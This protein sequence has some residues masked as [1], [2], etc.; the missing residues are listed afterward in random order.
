MREVQLLGDFVDRRSRLVFFAVVIVVGSV[1]H[2]APRDWNPFIVF[3]GVAFEV[4]GVVG[5]L[6]TL[7]RTGGE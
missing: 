6:A 1:M 4:I 3:P 7:V 5:F 2:Y